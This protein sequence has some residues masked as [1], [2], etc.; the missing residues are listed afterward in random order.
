[1]TQVYYT[2]IYISDHVPTFY[3]NIAVSTKFKSEK[4]TIRNMSKNNKNLFHE[5]L[6]NLNW[7]PIMN[8][9]NPVT[10]FEKFS[11]SINA[12]F[13][14]CFPYININV[15]TKKQPLNPWMTGALLI[16][17]KHKDKLAKTKIKN[18]TAVNIDRYKTYKKVYRM[19]IRKAKNSYYESKFRECSNDMKKTWN[20]INSII[21][22]KKSEGDLPNT[23]YDGN[24]SYNG[25][26]DIAE[27]FNEFFV[28]IGPSLADTI[29]VSNV[30]FESYLN[31]PVNEK[32]VFANVT[33]DT[34]LRTLSKLKSKSSTSF[35]NISTKLLK[36]I[37]HHILA[38][39]T[40]LFNLSFKTGYIPDNYKC[41]KIIPIYKSE[42][43]DKFTNYRPISILS[44]FSKLLEKVASIQMFKYI[45]KFKILY[46]HQY[47]FRANHDTNQPL[48]Q[49]LDKV[50]R[51]LNKPTSEYT[52]TIFLDLKKAFDT[53]DHTIMLRKLNN[54]GFREVTNLWFENYLL[55]RTQYVNI[56]NI[57]S[58]K[59]II[60][61]GIPQGSV[62]GPLLFLL[63][64]NDLPNATDFFTLLFA[65][66]TGLTKSSPNL[67]DLINKSN[68]EIAKAHAWF[69]A[70]K[71]SLNISKTKYIIF[72]NKN[73]PLDDQV[74]KIYI[75]NK[76]LL[77]IGN[78]CTDEYYKYV[79]IKLD[80]FLTFEHHINHVAGKVASATF[81]L[82]QVKHSLP[83]NIRI[84]VYNSLVKSHLE[85]GAIIWGLEN[86]KQISKIGKIQKRALRNV[87][88]TGFNSHTEPIL[89][90]LGLLLF[91]DLVQLNAKCF[92]YKYSNSALPQSFRNMFE[93]LVQFERSKNY[94]LEKIKYNGLSKFPTVTLPKIWN[95][96]PVITKNKTSLS[97]FKKTIITNNLSKYKS[98]KC[99][100]R[101]CYA[102]K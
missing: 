73:M 31:P 78:K 87:A 55:N 15:K 44:A 51:A 96:T 34:I 82:N 56:K 19:L 6:S 36:E 53:C 4:I 101:N 69:A 42:D 45:N 47:G 52:L 30:P 26:K 39:V 37:I 89:G 93:P 46:D 99:N 98:F 41:A 64:I 71:L 91:R 77:R 25:T 81:A 33:P 10:A 43:K 57:N 95:E 90:N 35:D 86:N 67:K 3:I 50:Y 68:E 38:P 84:T 97:T 62:L 49:L 12:N 72:R 32:F 24:I 63:Y 17:R 29:P 60:R 85:Y 8:D 11:T 1:M 88:K 7:D 59:Q 76:E 27:G 9:F 21:K 58:S 94:K 5:K 22:S 79:G 74:C 20:I 92:M 48:I 83:L 61:C 66:D 100:E 65:D 23:F 2:L 40:H 13:N 75:D 16:S 54:Y 80:E 28:N 14:E 18:P 102:C 70:N